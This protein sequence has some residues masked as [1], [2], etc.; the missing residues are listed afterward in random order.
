[1]IGIFLN[2]KEVSLY[3]FHIF[4]SL[5]APLEWTIFVAC[6]SRMARL[7]AQFLFLRK[8]RQ[9]CTYNRFFF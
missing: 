8:K 1:M 6:S 4:L 9:D 5:N 7:H 3:C 2:Q